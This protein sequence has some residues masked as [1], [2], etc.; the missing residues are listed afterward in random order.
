VKRVVL[1]LLVLAIVVSLAPRGAQARGI[2]NPAV[3]EV[4][5]ANTE[6]KSYRYGSA[7]HTGNGVFYSNG[8]VLKTDTRSPG[9]PIGVGR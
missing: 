1:W 8:H 2:P 9:V 5:W 4:F 7:F 6:G 3:V